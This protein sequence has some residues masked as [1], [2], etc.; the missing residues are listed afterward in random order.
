[1]ALKGDPAAL[2]IV[3]DRLWPRLRAQAPPVSIDA[4][5]DDLVATGK[6]VIDAALS[7]QITTDLLRDLLGALYLQGQITELTE[8]E[9]RLREL[10]E[11]A[12]DTPPW[13]LPEPPSEKL[14]IRG[15]KRRRERESTD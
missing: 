5:S 10:E 1:M 7:G 12:G 9:R 13:A 11:R 4:K 6:R 15:R 14:P 2:K 3:A 8:F